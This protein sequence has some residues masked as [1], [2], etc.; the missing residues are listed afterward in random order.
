M[1]IEPKLFCNECNLP[2]TLEEMV[3]NEKYGPGYKYLCKSCDAKL[4]RLRRAKDPEK[5]KKKA[6]ENY[7][8]YRDKI[9]LDKKINS[10]LP[11][12]KERKRIY[13]AKYKILK[14]K[15]IREKQ[16]LNE[17][18]RLLLDPL[19]KLKKNISHRIKNSLSSKGFLRGKGHGTWVVLGTDKEGLKQHFLSTQNID[20]LD[21]NLVDS[22]E[23]DHIC[24][25]AQA[26]NEKE[27]LRLNHYSNLQLIPSKD[28]RIKRHN[29]TK[30]A[31]EKCRLLLNRDWIAYE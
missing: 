22:L 5:T 17:A 30:E 24:P 16:R 26:I 6:K 19:F 20:I 14:R 2:K 21:K 4:A 12:E 27:I 15:E 23:L 3:L 28:N 29:R 9:L 10:A 31:E 8:K 7:I 18:K 11:A 1:K 13:N 25:L